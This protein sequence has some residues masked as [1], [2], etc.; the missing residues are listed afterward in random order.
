MKNKLA[1]SLHLSFLFF[2]NFGCTNSSSPT[3]NVENARSH[4]NAENMPIATDG[5]S[6]TVAR[7]R[8][9][10]GYIDLC[11]YAK[12]APSITTRLAQLIDSGFYDGLSF[13]RIIPGKLAQTGDPTGRGDGGSNQPF[14]ENENN[15]QVE[16]GSVVMARNSISD[17]FDSQFY[18]ALDTLQ[19]TNS[20]IVFG[21]IIYGL[22]IADSLAPNESIITMS[23]IPADQK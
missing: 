23:L 22:E 11:F 21:K 6:T 2:F 4:Y 10:K 20:G 3:D 17:Q 15:R 19:S 14:I 16:R 1:L 7:I 13:H 5:C 8:T 12:E 18:I 9:A